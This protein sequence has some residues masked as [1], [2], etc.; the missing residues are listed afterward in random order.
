MAREVVDHFQQTWKS[1]DEWYEA[2]P[3]LYK[4]ELAALRKAV[5]R[6]GRGLE[7][8]VGTGRCAAPLSV[9]YGVDP[10]AAM[11]G[12]ARKKGVRVVQGYGEALP[13]RSASFDFVQMVFVIEFVDDL[14]GFLSESARVLRSGGALITGFIDKDSSWGRHFQSSSSAR[15]YFHP[16]SP[17]E[18]IETLGS[19]GLESKGSW[20]A[21]FGPPPDLPRAER[22]R[23]GFG[24]GGFVVI[25]AV[26]GRGK[27]PA[28]A[29]V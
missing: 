16:P 22:P 6:R 25:K 5:P 26:K 13:F 23:T 21:L 3:A 24:Q 4:T 9:R 2:H 20:Q 12:L 8:G 1:Y 27:P 14:R 15:R 19:V 17:R 11:L 18:L 10:S 28:P 7:V 29:G